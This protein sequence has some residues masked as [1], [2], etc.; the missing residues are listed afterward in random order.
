VGQN[1]TMLAPPVN[2]IRWGVIAPE[3]MIAKRWME[4]CG[5]APLG[6]E[7]TGPNPTGARKQNL[8]LDKGYDYNE[9]RE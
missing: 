9:V 6:K 7:K 1:E 3:W 8:C 5:I 2:H 4:L